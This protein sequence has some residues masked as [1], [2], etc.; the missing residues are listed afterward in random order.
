MVAV[1]AE[2]DAHASL[3]YRLFGYLAYAVSVR[4]GVALPDLPLRQEV[5][6]SGFSVLP[7]EL[8]GQALHKHTEENA[9]AKPR[10]PL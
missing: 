6:K 8:F 5:G 1:C 7:Q 2:I 3:F 10:A 4:E 9:R